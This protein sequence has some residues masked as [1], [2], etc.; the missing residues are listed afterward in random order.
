MI[1]LLIP[2][3]FALAAFSGAAQTTGLTVAVTEGPYYVTGT[4]EL[5]DGNLNAARLPGTA[6][7]LT[8][9]VYAGASGTTPVAGA[10][11]EFWQADDGG[12]Y[13]PNGNGPASKYQASEIALRGFVT[14]AKDGS[15]SLSTIYPGYYEGRARHLHFR[16][17]APG[18]QEVISQLIFE[19]KPGDGVTLANDSIAL[20]L[21][22]WQKIKTDETSR[23]AKASF[24]IR[25]ARR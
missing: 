23:P 7:K 24:D 3:T 12:S 19:P 4:A 8:G 10:K 25:L 9:K 5:Q 2:L 17:T 20:S 21:P 14:S 22:A 18:Y 6:V 16:V 13:H 1:R 15:W 11:I